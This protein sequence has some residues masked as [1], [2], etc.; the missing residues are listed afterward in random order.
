[1]TKI[2]IFNKSNDNL[3]FDIFKKFSDWCRP[4]IVCRRSPEHHDNEENDGEE[5]MPECIVDPQ[6][7]P[8]LHNARQRLISA[9]QHL[10]TARQFRQNTSCRWAS[11]VGSPTAWNSLSDNLRG[12]LH[13]SSSFR[14]GLKTVLFARYKYAIDTAKLRPN[15]AIQIY[16]Y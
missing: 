15:G 11:A 8:I 13:C 12:P 6:L 3:R 14:H 7:S 4:L 5:Q 16:Y 2:Y 9:S 10:L 1:M